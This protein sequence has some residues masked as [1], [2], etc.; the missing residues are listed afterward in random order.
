MAKPA[1][2]VEPPATDPL[3]AGREALAR[4]AWQDAFDLLSRADR[5]SELSGTDLESLAEAAIFAAHADLATGVKERAFKAHLA[6]ENPLRAAYVALDLARDYGY[7]G[8]SSIASAWA[9]RGERLIDG[10]PESYASGYLALVKSE[11]ASASGNIDAALEL[12]ERAVEIASR[13]AH[14]DLQ[15]TALTNLGGLKIATGAT[16]DGMALM[17]EAAISAVNG[18]LS[19]FATGVTCCTMIA[20]C[21]DLTDYRRAS[22]WTEATD[23][24]CERQSVSGFPGACR[25]HRAEVTALSGAWDRAEE[26]LRRAAVEL[27]GYNAIPPLADGF[28]AIGEIRRLKGDFEAAETALREANALGRT[29]H[30]ALAL[31]RLAQGNVR[32]AATAINSAVAEQSWDQWARAR[33]LPA[34]VEIAVAAGDPTL[35]RTAADELAR[36]VDTYSSPALEAGRHQ[37]LARVL[38]AEGD[39]AGAAREVRV[40]IRHWRE[41]AAPY[42]VARG[43]ALLAKALRATTDE[44]AADLE[45]QAARDEFARL[46][47][48][49]DE[50]AAERELQ[51]AIERRTGPV[52]A[53]KTFMFTDIVGSTNLAE[54]LGDKAWER[55]LRWHDDMLRSVVA[56][57]GGEIV[58]STGDGFFVAF[59]SARQGIE[60]ARSIQRALADHRQ[61]SGF[62]LSVRIGL[63]TADANRR[64]ADYSGVG[65]HLTARVASLAGGGEILATAETLAEAGE[66]ATSGAREVSLKGVSTP[67]AIATVTWSGS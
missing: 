58:N 27:S 14:A 31:I 29:P 13:A 45:L 59:D 20:A 48:K 32:A 63:H 7:A 15:A 46:G 30:P 54:L 49:P 43:R 1:S 38:L 34:Q 4:H 21:R 26:E 36:I 18:E 5:E 47:A 50:R 17:E 23:K 16:S 62:A 22:E 64:G 6:E 19:P 67:L 40:A 24:Y 10:K 60:C 41:V 53:R 44:D 3:T 37:A 56:K 8:K 52:Q 28:Y 39:A 66:E 55:L 2:P 12:A 11:V 61:D 42:D 25:I 51:A 9:R 65:V 35:A 57:S 33:L